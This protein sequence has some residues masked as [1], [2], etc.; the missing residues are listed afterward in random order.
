M[1]GATHSNVLQQQLEEVIDDE[2]RKL[3]FTSLCKQIALKVVD[4]VQKID[5][6]HSEIKALY[7]EL[8]QQVAKYVSERDNPP[9]SQTTPISANNG[10]MGGNNVKSTI[11]KEP[12]TIILID[13]D[14]DEVA[15]NEP[16]PVTTNTLSSMTTSSESDSPSVSIAEEQVLDNGVSDTQINGAPHQHEEVLLT[17][18]KDKETEDVEIEDKYPDEEVDIIDVT[19]TA[20][21]NI[22]ISEGDSQF[23]LDTS[24]TGSQL[25]VS[26][27]Q[28]TAISS[29]GEDTSISSQE[30]APISSQEDAPISSQEDAPISSQD[31]HSAILS[32]SESDQVTPVSSQDSMNILDEVDTNTASQCSTVTSTQPLDVSLDVSP[33]SSQ[34]LSSTQEDLNKSNKPPLILKIT[35]EKLDETAETSQYSITVVSPVDKP[36]PA[37][38]KDEAVPTKSKDKTVSNQNTNQPKDSSPHIVPQTATSSIEQSS[39]SL[40]SAISSRKKKTFQFKANSLVYAKPIESDIWYEAE[41][42]KEVPAVGKKQPKYQVRFLGGQKLRQ[43]ILLKSIATKDPADSEQYEIGTRVVAGRPSDTVNTTISKKYKDISSGNNISV[44]FAGVVAELACEAN[45][46]RYLVFFDDGYAQYFAITSLYLVIRPSREVWNDVAIDC[47]D[48][49]KEY[50]QG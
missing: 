47:R 35:T 37:Q 49:I 14:D 38:D 17:S 4:R 33:S 2:L 25:S 12:T 29:Q 5:N 15:N 30:D 44:M 36:V 39:I 45:R 50:L 42:L 48:F 24:V 16:E 27:T 21:S 43:K 9:P 40:P 20:A 18:N 6:D 41:L 1:V 8:E 11:N 32:P 31:T 22:D 7:G 13:D 10:R 46:Y 26:A 34:S 19:T 3:E 23:T 28:D